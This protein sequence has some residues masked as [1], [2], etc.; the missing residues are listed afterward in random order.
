MHDG[1]HAVRA[2][3]HVAFT[4]FCA[5][6]HAV[7]MRTKYMHTPVDLELSPSIHTDSAYVHQQGTTIKKLNAAVATAVTPLFPDMSLGVFRHVA[8]RTSDSHLCACCSPCCLCFFH[9][10]LPTLEGSISQQQL[11]NVDNTQYL[12]GVWLFRN[13][14]QDH[15][16]ASMCPMGKQ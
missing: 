16:L 8:W 7:N 2:C 12:A 11:A 1:Y 3:T 9:A 15:P 14:H 4:D 13:L 6:L 5:Q 10:A